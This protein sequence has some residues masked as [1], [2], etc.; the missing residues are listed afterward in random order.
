MLTVEE[1]LGHVWTNEK[2]DLSR[3]FCKKIVIPSAFIGDPAFS[4]IERTGFP[5]KITAGMT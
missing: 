3:A 1:K 2:Q 5:T 4:T